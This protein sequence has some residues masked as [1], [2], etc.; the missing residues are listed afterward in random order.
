MQYEFDLE[1][2]DEFIDAL[3]ASPAVV[4]AANLDAMRKSVFLVEAE[5]KALVPRRTGRLFS[6]IQ[7][8][9]AAGD[10]IQGTVGTNVEYAPFVEFGTGPHDIAPVHA[11]ALHFE[12]GGRSVF[13]AR[14]HHPGTKA[15]P[16]LGPALERSKPSIIGFFRDAAQKVI[17]HLA[18]K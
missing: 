13:A 5:A 10:E 1:G 4:Y 6:S 17:D 16:Y 7:G 18:G 9:V 11:L 3:G 8:D 15:E 14:V 2:V 12:I